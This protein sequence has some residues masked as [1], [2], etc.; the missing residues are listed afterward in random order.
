MRRVVGVLAVVLVAGCTS[1]TPLPRMSAA[2]ADA[3]YEP[4]VAAVQKAVSDSVSGVVWNPVTPRYGSD[5]ANRCVYQVGLVGGTWTGS[6]PLQHAPAELVA[7][8]E[9]P[10]SAHGF[11]DVKGEIVQGATSVKARDAKGAEL[12]LFE[13]P[14]SIGISVNVGC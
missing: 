1:T 14:G 13:R 10:A 12:T 11:R 8:V 4:L 6:P 5:T 2:D 9:A 3:A 7:V